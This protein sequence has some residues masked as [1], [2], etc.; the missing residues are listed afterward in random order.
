MSNNKTNNTNNLQLNSS[1]PSEELTE[2]DI[3][4]NLFLDS[5]IKNNTTSTDT[6]NSTNKIT[7]TANNSTT[8]KENGNNTSTS[9]ST[10][11]NTTEN[12][13]N[14]SENV[15]QKNVN[16]SQGSNTSENT[17]ELT[18]SNESNGS[19]TE[20][21]TRKTLGSSAGL[22]FSKALLQLKEFYDKYQLDQQVIDECKD[23]F[24]QIW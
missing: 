24:I 8:N 18:Q 5:A 3:S 14:S 11:N 10:E 16:E 22:P 23:L 2:N 21:Y 6:E 13:S 19:T 7:N 12:T 1:F 17:S 20:S 15:T 4:D 9:E